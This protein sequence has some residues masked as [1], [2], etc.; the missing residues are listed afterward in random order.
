MPRIAFIDTEVQAQSGRIQDIGATN[1]QDGVFHA[2]ALE[3]FHA[4]IDST[5]F[6]C[7]HNVIDHDKVYLE[8]WIGPEKLSKYRFIDTLFL[9]PLLFPEKPYHKLVKDDKLDP[10]NLNNPYTD[11]TKARDLFYDEVEKFRQ[12]D[13]LLQQIYFKLLGDSEY[14]RSFFS[15]L[16]R[17]ETPETPETPESRETPE[18]TEPT[19]QLIRRYFRGQCCENKSLAT[20]INEDPV[21][22][23]Y[24]LALITCSSRES[25]TPPWVLHRFPNVERY[26]FQLRSDPCLPGCAYCNQSFDAVQIHPG[27][28]PHRRWKEPHLP[29]AGADGR[30]KCTCADGDHLAAPV[31]DEGPGG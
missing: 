1:D 23:A 24:T 8:K 16:Q 19:E 17:S 6:L 9:S 4:F 29:G 3:D 13:L 20:F 21:A 30:E 14:F 11:S 28:L 5:P 27:H 7:G 22:L 15:F 2:N 18:T 31:A 10:E 25:I 12:T 26:L